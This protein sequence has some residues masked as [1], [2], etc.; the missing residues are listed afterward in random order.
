MICLNLLITFINLA[1]AGSCWVNW[2]LSDRK[3]FQFTCEVDTSQNKQCL[4][5][6]KLKLTR[7]SYKIFNECCRKRIL[8]LVRI[9]GA[10]T[11][12]CMISFF[13]PT[14]RCYFNSKLGRMLLVSLATSRRY[15]RPK[16][17]RRCFKFSAQCFVI[18][19]KHY[20]I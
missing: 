4:N 8:L 1:Q 12:E 3:L 15:F 5:R 11:F 20:H 18:G 14:K 13:S 10:I 19:L 2:S 6:S 9:L 17:Q 7:I 16:I